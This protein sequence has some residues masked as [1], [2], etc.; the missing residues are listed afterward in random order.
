[1]GGE[2]GEGDGV[3]ELGATGLTVLTDT[4]GIPH[5]PSASPIIIVLASFINR[6][7]AG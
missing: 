6:T 7:P 2:V 1:M 5:P 4:E 3:G